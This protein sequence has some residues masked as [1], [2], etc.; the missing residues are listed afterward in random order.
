MNKKLSIIILFLL[1]MFGCQKAGKQNGMVEKEGGPV[2]SFD[3]NGG[4]IPLSDDLPSTTSPIEKDPSAIPN[5]IPVPIPKP[6]YTTQSEQKDVLFTNSENPTPVLNSSG[7]SVG[8]SLPPGSLINV[9]YQ[10]IMKYDS[11]TK[12]TQIDF[13]SLVYFETRPI[14]PGEQIVKGYLSVSDLDLETSVADELEA[15]DLEQR[16]Q[17]QMKAYQSHP[18]IISEDRK[19]N[20]KS[21]LYQF[22]KTICADNNYSKVAYIKKWQAFVN[23]KPKELQQIARNAMYLDATART[24]LYEAQRKSSFTD[25]KYHPM[26]AQCQWD[27]L[28]MSI[29]NRAQKK[30]KMYGGQYKT[31]MLGVATNSQYNIWFKKYVSRNAYRITSCFLNPDIEKIRK[32]QGDKEIKT[33]RNHVEDFK[34]AV[35]RFPKVLGLIDHN[36]PNPDDNYLKEIFAFD[37]EKERLPLVNQTGKLNREGMSYLSNLTHYYHPG[38]M[39]KCSVRDYT[40][41]KGEELLNGFIKVIKEETTEFYIV[42]NNKLYLKS[43]EQGE[44]LKEAKVIV[45]RLEKVTNLKPLENEPVTGEAEYWTFRILKDGKYLTANEYFGGD[46]YI[47]QTDLDSRLNSRHTSKGCLPQGHFSQCLAGQELTDNGRKIPINWFDKDVLHDFANSLINDFDLV[48]GIKYEVKSSSGKGLP[49]AVQCHSEDM[50]SAIK[51]KD[52]Q[53]QHEE[54]PYFGGT[55]DSNIMLATGVDGFY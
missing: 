54:F 1:P 18:D 10:K 42:S 24:V 39:P 20:T 55:C 47:Y 6:D 31:D 53:A 51:S 49:I 34:E 23:A 5:P 9:T 45:Q 41:S 11:K 29:R 21:A 13:S 32:Q 27:I 28:A 8:E 7:E 16:Y 15:K 44:N 19:L 52:K 50:F 43:K 30:Y 36:S 14:L 12:K 40:L 46:A 33:Y 4:V 37:L 3:S 35:E 22:H 48:G 26:S 2:F 17:T 38:G 25:T